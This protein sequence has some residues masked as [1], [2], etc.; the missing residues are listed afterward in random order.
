MSN[1]FVFDLC[2]CLCVFMLQTLEAVFL[3]LSERSDSCLEED[4]LVCTHQKRE[5]LEAQGPTL[6]FL[7]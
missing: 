7:P 2:L 6:W 1:H 4:Y 5:S 3:R